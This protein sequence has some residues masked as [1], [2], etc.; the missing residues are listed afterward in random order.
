MNG[1]QSRMKRRPRPRIDRRQSE[2][3]EEDVGRDRD[4][5]HDHQAGQDDDVA[6][7]HP[8]HEPVV[9][10]MEVG[11]RRDPRPGSGPAGAATAVP[12]TAG[13]RDPGDVT[14]ASAV[15]PSSSVTG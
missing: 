9:P 11:V 4:A 8:E 7:D 6:G 2:P 15:S 13:A 1:T 12:A 3:D 14:G 5:A 10:A